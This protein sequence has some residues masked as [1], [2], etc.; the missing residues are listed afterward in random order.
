MFNKSPSQLDSVF[1]AFRTT[2]A[3]PLKDGNE[4]AVFYAHQEEIGDLEGFPLF[5]MIRRVGDV[6]VNATVSAQTLRRLG[7][8]TPTIP[9]E[10]DSRSYDDSGELLCSL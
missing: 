2:Y 6:P 8:S 5:N 1:A 4:V 10:N 9:D 7:Y 3:T